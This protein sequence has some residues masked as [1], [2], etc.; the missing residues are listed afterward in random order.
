MHD[1]M[2]GAFFERVLKY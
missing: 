2:F 1:G